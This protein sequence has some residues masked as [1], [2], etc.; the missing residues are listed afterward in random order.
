MICRTAA[1]VFS[2]FYLANIDLCNQADPRAACYKASFR[3]IKMKKPKAVLIE[4]V[5]GI[6]KNKK[7]KKDVFMRWIE[8]SL[9][10]FQTRCK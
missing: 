7:L 1:F 8:T 6:L 9:G 5:P 10:K 4:Q 3:Y 2:V